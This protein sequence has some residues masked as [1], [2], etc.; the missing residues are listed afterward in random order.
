MTK[1]QTKLLELARE[2]GGHYSITTCY[3]RGPKG[4]KVRAGMRERDALFA[5]EKL[6]FV[7]ITNRQPWSET[8]RGYTQSGNSI[9]FKVK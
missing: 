6:G 5:L 9:A 2:Y 3:G 4:G 7:V 1:T 8:N